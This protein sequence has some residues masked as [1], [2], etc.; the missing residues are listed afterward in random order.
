MNPSPIHLLLGAFA[1]GLLGA[2]V[3][4]W[5]LSRSVRAQ[6]AV[7]LQVQLRA[8]MGALRE[9]LPLQEQSPQ[10]I[11]LAPSDALDRSVEAL[12]A[13]QT[14]ASSALSGVRAAVAEFASKAQA[15]S[16]RDGFLRQEMHALRQ[17]QEQ[18]AERLHSAAHAQAE[19]QAQQFQRQAQQ[20]QSMLE[21]WVQ[22]LRETMP[23]PASALPSAQ[24]QDL[25]PY[26]L[27]A[28]PLI[29]QMQARIA[30]ELEAQRQ[31]IKQAQ[32]QAGETLQQA[33]QRVPQLVQRAI[34]IELEF[35]T[36]QQVGRDEARAAELRALL[37]ALAVQPG[38]APP[39]VATQPP[40]PTNRPVTPAPGASP[41]SPQAVSARPP[42]LMHAPL[43]RPQ[44]TYEIETPEPELSDEE[45][46]ALP[47]EIPD[48]G[49]P[50]KRILPAP[51]K[52]SLRDL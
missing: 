46:D 13:V 21:G 16:E 7:Q 6:L 52:P 23:A 12:Q 17:A 31:A 14:A 39:V 1:L 18:A 30:T 3:G 33:L 34:Q 35:Q 15:V 38:K 20:F 50:R 4:A 47:P 41:V 25:P 49:R 36:Q 45:I 8:Q 11:D 44:P 48:A 51:K 29:E 26:R 40:V 2:V 9:A 19:Q 27:D 37:Q 43:P 28:G 32:Q 5:I 24:P 10:R 42:E 22:D